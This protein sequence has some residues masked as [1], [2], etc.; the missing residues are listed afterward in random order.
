M[1]YVLPD[2]PAPDCINRSSGHSVS[3]RQFQGVVAAGAD[4]WNIR[5]PELRLGIARA[6]SLPALLVSVFHIVLWCA[7]RQMRRVYAQWRV[8]GMEHLKPRLDWSVFKFIGKCVRWLS[9]FSN[10][11]P[12]LISQVIAKP[13]VA[14]KGASG[15]QPAPVGS[16]V[17]ELPKPYGGVSIVCNEAL[18][19]AVRGM[20]GLGLLPLWPKKRFSATGV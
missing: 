19:T 17:H 6:A 7:G 5:L 12:D 2:I 20:M 16:L 18:P 1:L 8:T 11:K 14:C 4:K 9:H 3:G 10:H 15:P 13:S